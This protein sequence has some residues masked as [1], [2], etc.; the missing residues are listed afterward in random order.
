MMR[1]VCVVPAAM[2]AISLACTGPSTLGPPPLGTTVGGTASDS[3]V[4]GGFL[5]PT[6]DPCSLA[7]NGP[8]DTTSDDGG[9]VDG[10]TGGAFKF[11]VGAPGGAIGFSLSCD[12][13][14]NAPSNLGCIFW[15]V[16]LPNDERGTHMSPPASTQAFAVVVANVSAL[17]DAEVAIYSGDSN[18]AVATAVVAPAQTQVFDLG[19]ASIS[20]SSSTTGGTAFRIESDVPIAAYQ[21]NPSTNVIEVYSNDASLL[22]PEQALGTDYTAATADGILLGMSANDPMPINAGAFVAVVATADDTT[23]E[24]TAN[25]ELVGTL[26]N[27]LVLRRGVVAT[28]LSNSLHTDAGNLSGTTV[29]ANKPVAVFA[30][31]VATAIPAANDVC[32]ADHLEHQLLPVTAWGTRYAVAP[33][34]GPDDGRDAHTV[35]RV[36]AG[37]QGADLI[38]CPEQPPG[39]PTSLEPGESVA[40]ATDAAFTVRSDDDDESFSLVQFAHSNTEV[41]TEGLGDPAMAIVV[42]AGQFERRSVFLVPA[43]YAAN[44]ATLVVRGDGEVRVDGVLIDADRFAEIG[45]LAGEKHRYLHLDVP[46]G[47][48]ALEAEAPAGVTVSGVDTA[49]GYAFAGGTGVRVLSLPPAAG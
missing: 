43:G 26:P 28:I 49:V 46:A 27:P 18:E 20:A 21:F 29:H 37:D 36:V 48:H 7:V 30:G 31:N 11:D 35:Y 5:P 12:D 17:R 15:A 32:C 4:D 42:P 25:T 13:V 47:T 14:A 19:E 6:P 9:A 45:Y 16:D 8:G 23:V 40:F 44:W 41:S 34:P 33:L 22:L 1:I 3:G 38:F 24:I 10:S 2:T 39:A